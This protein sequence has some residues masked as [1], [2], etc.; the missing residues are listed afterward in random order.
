MSE[1][2][3]LP[4]PTLPDF[5]HAHMNARMECSSGRHC[6]KLVLGDAV[7]GPGAVMLMTND[8]LSLAADQRISRA[9]ADALLKEG[10]GDA[11]SRVFA[12]HRKDAHRRFELRV[13]AMMGAEDAALSMSGYSANVGLIEAFAVPGHPV[14]IDIRAHASLWSGVACGK[15]QARPFRHNNVADLDKKMA[16]YGPG[17]V[18]VDSLYSTSGAIAPLADIVEVVERHG[19]ILVVD[20]THSFGTHGPGGAGLCV[21]LGLED[22]VHFRTAGLSKAIAARG[23]LVI[24]SKKAIEYYRYEANAMIFSTAV[25]GYEIAGFDTTLDII[26]AEPD[27]TTRLHDNHRYLKTGLHDLG[28][29]VSASDSQIISIV[30]GPNRDTIRFRDAL[31]REGVFGS[32][33]LPPAT[34]KDESLIRFT[35]NADLVEDELDH[36]I[37]ACHAARPVVAPER[38]RRV[39][40]SV[41]GTMAPS[42]S[43]AMSGAVSLR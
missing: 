23:G 9:K 5:L 10:H 31:A 21:E 11:I 43:Q 22:R 40:P 15:A 38:L 39:K 27:R 8:Y 26:S 30:T 29:D 41:A 32:V 20:E 12:H 1:Q 34:P 7:P 42:Q 24:G 3:T 14:Y 2:K 18:V 4:T 13:A 36:V 25:L 19:G 35:L 33:F 28:Y 6:A 16:H 37:A 17:L